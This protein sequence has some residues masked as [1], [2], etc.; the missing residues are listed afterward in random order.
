VGNPARWTKKRSPYFPALGLLDFHTTLVQNS[1]KNPTT[2]RLQFQRK[3]IPALTRWVIPP[4]KPGFFI[5]FLR[6]SFSD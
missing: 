1:H 5:P 6:V 2:L 3:K 4:S